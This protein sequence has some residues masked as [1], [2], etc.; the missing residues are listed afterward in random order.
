MLSG[1]GDSRESLPESRHEEGHIYSALVWFL[2]SSL[3]SLLCF[4][5]H[6]LGDVPVSLGESQGVL[7]H[8]RPK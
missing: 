4:L 7:L 8:E 2:S 6:C 5:S 1:I 3:H